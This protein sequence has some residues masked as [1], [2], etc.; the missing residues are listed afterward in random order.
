PDAG[1]TIATLFAI[2]KR[3][4]YNTR[5]KVGTVVDPKEVERRRAERDARVAQDAQQREV[6]RKHAASLALAIIEKAEPARDDHPYLLRKGVSAVDTLYE[7]DDTKLLKLIGYRPQCG[8]AHL[9]GR[10]LIAPV[11]INGAITTV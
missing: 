11:T 3:Y 1:I 6:K 4:G 10:I 7:I 8:G 5:S 9:E 2:A